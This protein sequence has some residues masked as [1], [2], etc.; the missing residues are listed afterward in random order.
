M[1]DAMTF[2]RLLAL[3]FAVA[4]VFAP[5]GMPAMAEPTAPT[6]HHA[7][8]GE[9]HCDRQSTPDNHHK[10]ADK[11][12]CAAMCIAMVVPAGVA[13]PSPYLADRERPASDHDRRGYLGEIATPPPKLA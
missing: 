7:M 9:G 5:I 12:C 13:Q 4:M 8:P 11:S 2:R 1:G 3:L 6:A 10:A